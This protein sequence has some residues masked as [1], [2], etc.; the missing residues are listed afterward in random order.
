MRAVAIVPGTPGSA[1]LIEVP[2]PPIS[3][4]S[5]LVETS[6]IGICGT[7]SELISGHYGEA[8][9]G[10]ERLIIGH[11]S[12]GHVLDAPEDSGFAQGDL[13]TGIVRRP[14]PVPCNYCAVGQWDMCCNG[15]YTERGIKGRNG[16]ASERFRIEPEF[17]VKIPPEL[18]LLGVLV[19]PASI[20]AKAWNHIERIGNRSSAWNPKTVLVTGAGTIGLLA[21]MIACQKGLEVHLLDHNTEGPKPQLGRRLGAIYHGGDATVLGD[22][23]PDVI[24]ECTG[25]VP[26]I[27]DCLRRCS[28]SGVL[29]LTGISEPEETQQVHLGA[30]NRRIVLH[31]EAVFGTVNANRIHYKMAVDALSRADPEWLNSLLTRKVPVRNWREA[32]EDRDD[33]I[34][35]TLDFRP[36]R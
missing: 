22:F 36:E 21:A 9:S 17:A 14:D 5:M 6:L 29:C 7:D 27:L 32:L 19:E 30:I 13:V 28:P 18:E 2:E 33:D 24:L 20:L 31:N 23:A 35:V 1:D 3:D 11:E 25:A 16:Y 10:S 8:P 26:V 34:K 15:L 4:G 12:I